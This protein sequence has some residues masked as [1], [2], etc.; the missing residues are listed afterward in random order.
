LGTLLRQL[1]QNKTSEF[2]GIGFS[3]IRKLEESGVKTLSDLTVL[4]SKEMAV[5][6]LRPKTADQLKNYLRRR[7]M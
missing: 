7:L 3:S 6:G 5:L 4:T 2:R 1:K